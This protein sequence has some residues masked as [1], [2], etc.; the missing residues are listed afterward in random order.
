MVWDFLPGCGRV[1][2]SNIGLSRQIAVDQSSQG[3]DAQEFLVLYLIRC[4]IGYYACWSAKE[5]KG[6]Y[7]VND[8][9]VPRILSKA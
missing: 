2:A 1:T 3:S 7:A 6:L 9:F 4:V 5:S 8:G